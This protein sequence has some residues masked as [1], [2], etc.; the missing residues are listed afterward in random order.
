MQRFSRLASGLSSPAIL[1]VV[2][3]CSAL[4]CV[5][6]G[7]IDY[8]GQPSLAV[9]VMVAAGVSLFIL[10]H[11]AG[12]WC[13]VRWFARQANVSAP[14]LRSLNSVVT[15]TSLIG[16]GG[17]GLIAFDRGML[18]GISNSGYAELLRCAPGLV[19]LIEIRRTP[20]LY[21]GYL[22]FSFGFA[23]LALFLLKGEEIRGWAA[24]AA[25]LS[26]V[27]PVG[28]AVLY[29]GRM[30]ILFVLVMI[31]SVMLVRISQGRPSLPRGHYLLLKTVVLV[32]LFVIYSSAIWSRRSN[33]CVQM[34][35][36]IQ[37]LKQRKAG[38]D[39][40]Y[41][42]VRREPEPNTQD[43]VGDR[44][45]RLPPPSSIPATDVSKMVTDATSTASETTEPPT[46]AP[47]P[48]AV[49]VPAVNSIEDL[50]VVMRESWNVQPRAYIL[51][52]IDSSGLSSRAAITFLSTYFYLTHGIRAADNTWRGRENLS[53]QWGLYEV[54][55][56]SP[57]LRVFRP[58]DQRVADMET[59]LRD[60][61]IYGFFP[62]VWAAAYID[63][64]IVGG[65]IYILIWGFVGGWS[66]AGA[67]R[68]ALVT[69]SLLLVFILASI[70]LSP[71]QGP[72][73]VA[74]SVLVLFSMI[75]T[76]ATIDLM[77]MRDD[78]QHASRQ[79]KLG[80]SAS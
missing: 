55:I 37:E 26:I 23:S 14:A 69:P 66:S 40:E 10:G 17:I 61:G 53:P 80:G 57:I 52:A 1:I 60:A 54:G 48:T 79:L 42:K 36:V 68:S 12:V 25:Q 73:G 35:G 75:V 56:L 74:N 21:I 67:R 33:F 50:L 64:G 51:S 5:A 34:G 43:P 8:P 47:A 15:A 6:I 18:S 45:S 24:I 22:S 76:G 70:V 65:V 44:A 4:A 7:P 41:A 32:L 38:R 78:S 46:A 3:W 30:P 63:F 62:T 77:R 9:L 19:D 31:V 29:S 27:C 16:I 58:N 71:V 28:Y 49:I 11:G 72:L 13:F 39:T 59:Q 2:I 20:L